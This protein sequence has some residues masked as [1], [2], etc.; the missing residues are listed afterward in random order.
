[1]R[2]LKLD[3]RTVEYLWASDINYDG[4]RLEVR[5]IDRSALFDISI[6]D[7]GD[8]TINTFGNDAPAGLIEA[9]LELARK[10]R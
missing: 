10:R 5:S 8:I 2:T 9:A 7:D 4:I 1:M 3:G 6:P